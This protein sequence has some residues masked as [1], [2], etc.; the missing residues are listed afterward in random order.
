M[1]VFGVALTIILLVMTAT[2][3]VAMIIKDNSI[4]DIVYGLAFLLS[5]WAAFLCCGEA[6]PRAL[7]A[8]GLVTLWGGRLA[9]HIFLRKRGEEEDFRYRQWREEWG[10]LFV[11]RSFLQIFMLQGA[12]VFIVALPVFLVIRQPGGGLGWLDLLGTLVWLLG[13]TFEA[14]GDFQL[15]RFKS[16]PSNKGR[17]MQSGLWR[18]TRHPNYFG[19]ATLWWGLFF[20]ALGVPYGWVAVVSPLLIDFLLLKVSG[21]PMLEAKY[22]GDPEFEAY[23]QRTNTFFPWLPKAG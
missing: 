8:L 5:C 10:A 13:F 14:V 17:I 2:F 15:M 19:E 3:V 12:V 4:V 9:G 7:L 11:P 20:I 18:Y 23:K 16:D 21:I 1:G 22:E 6:H